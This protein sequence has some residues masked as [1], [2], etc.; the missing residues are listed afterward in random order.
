MIGVR[1][2]SLPPGVHVDGDWHPVRADDLRFLVDE[3]SHP[4][5]GERRFDQEIFDAVFDLVRG[6]ETFLVLDFFLINDFAGDPGT[7]PRALSGELLA[8]LEERKRERPDLAVLLV[9]DPINRVYGGE[10]HPGLERLE[11][12]GVEVAWTRLERLRDSNPMYSAVYRMLFSWWGNEAGG[13]VLPNPFLAGDETTLRSWLRLLNFKANHRKLVVAGFE[14]APP[15][16]LVTSANPHDASSAHSN[17]ALRFTGE[18]ALDLAASELEVARWSGAPLHDDW[19]MA[20]EEARAASRSSRAAEPAEARI[21]AVTEGA[22]RDAALEAL[23]ALE[24][25][26]EVDLAMFYM[27]HRE[28]IDA[29]VA[30][31][32]RGVRVRLVLDANRDAFGRTKNGIPNRSVVH[33]LRRR[34]ERATARGGLPIEVRWARTAGEQFHTKVLVWRR[35]QNSMD[36]PGSARTGVLLGSANWTRRNLDDFNLEANVQIDVA[37]DAPV[38]REVER[39]FEDL[40]RRPDLSVAESAFVDGSRWSTVRYRVMEATGLSTF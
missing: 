18:A 25:G 27:G 19:E 8:A 6:A 15:V 38:A 7:A 26:D 2:R 23:A 21:R 31:A 36:R 30:A 10:R 39:W 32:G 9:T 20:L 37:A 5:P 33:E 16:G 3:T 11:Q 14:N 13:G 22:I 40:W 1:W 4:A 24:S 34:S 35:Q 29:L 17:V 12:A 28:L